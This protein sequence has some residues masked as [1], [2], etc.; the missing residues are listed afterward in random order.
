LKHGLEHEKLPEKWPLD[1]RYAAEAADDET[2]VEVAIAGA[3]CHYF[4]TAERTVNGSLQLRVSVA[5]I[6]TAGM[7]I[8][9]KPQT[10]KSHRPGNSFRSLLRYLV[11][12][13]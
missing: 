2:T 11:S 4:L 6:C 10:S 1:S 8:L 3:F 5:M 13:P 9:A 7:S 12:F